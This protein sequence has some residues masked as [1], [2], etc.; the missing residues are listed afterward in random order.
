MTDESIVALYWDRNE[1]AILETSRKYGNYCFTIAFNI[2][3]NKEDSEECVN[4]TYNKT[5]NSIPTQRPT[6]LQAFL[7]KITRNISLNRYKENTAQKRGGHRFE[8]VLDEIGE[9]SSKEPS[10]EEAAEEGELTKAINDFLGSL[11]RDKRVMFVRRYWYSDDVRDIADR[12][13]IPENTV[14]VTLRRIRVKLSSYLTERGFD[15]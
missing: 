7:G 15:L 2:L 6:L 11:P 3:S 4:D 13:N 9:I 8:V 10:P 14:S 12:M 1:D 5:W